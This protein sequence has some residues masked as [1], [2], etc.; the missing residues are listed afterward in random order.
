MLRIKLEYR[1]LGKTSFLAY[2]LVRRLS[3]KRPTIVQLSAEA[4]YVLFNDLGA[5]IFN[6]TRMAFSGRP[7]AE[8]GFAAAASLALPDLW[9]LSDGTS[10]MQVPSTALLKTSALVIHAASPVSDRWYQW[11][12]EQRAKLYVMDLWEESEL[13]ALLFAIAS[14]SYV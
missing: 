4:S 3:E 12:K 10:D 7:L 6:G 13:G 9:A 5:S 1:H 14:F 11:K 2:V 8:A